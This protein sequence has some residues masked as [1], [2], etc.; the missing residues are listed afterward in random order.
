MLT[1][2]LQIVTH[3]TLHFTDSVLFVIW[4]ILFAPFNSFFLKKKHA[5]PR[6]K[7]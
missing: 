6:E 3:L 5:K 1:R 4:S 7:S 2:D